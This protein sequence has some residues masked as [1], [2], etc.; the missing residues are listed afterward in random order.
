MQRTERLSK[1]CWNVSFLS[2]PF[3]Q[4]LLWVV[5][6]V[7]QEDQDLRARAPR[8]R[9]AQR[10]K[11]ISATRFSTSKTASKLLDSSKKILQKLNP[12]EHPCR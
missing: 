4:R 12:L 8:P 11:S 10:S 7:G 1:K 9:L 3:E 6:G 5:A 2:K